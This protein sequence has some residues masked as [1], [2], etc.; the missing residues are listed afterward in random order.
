MSDWQFAQGDQTERLAKVHLFS[1]MKKDVH[2]AEV[3]IH[4]TVREYVTPRDP[5][6]R[7]FATADRDTSAGRVRYH[8]AGWG[9]TLLEALSMCMREIHRFPLE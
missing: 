8:P 3:E 1:M 2:G 4:V 6:M 5:A 9:A 7:F